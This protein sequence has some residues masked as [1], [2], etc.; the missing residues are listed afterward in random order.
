M[1]CRLVRR[2]NGYG[3]RANRQ[4]LS[5]LIKFVAMHSDSHAASMVDCG[6]EGEC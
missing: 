3:P 1:E 2:V 6:T 4:Y 5:S